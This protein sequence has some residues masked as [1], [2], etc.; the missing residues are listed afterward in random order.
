MSRAAVLRTH[1]SISIRILHAGFIFS[2][3]Q[4]SHVLAAPNTGEKKSGLPID[5]GLRSPVHWPAA[6]A[7]VHIA[8][9]STAHSR[10]L[11]WTAWCRSQRRSEATH[12]EA[13]AARQWSTPPRAR[14]TRACHLRPPC[15]AADAACEFQPPPPRLPLGSAR[16]WEARRGGTAALRCCSWPATIESSKQPR[17]PC[18]TRCAAA[19][20]A[21]PRKGNL[22]WSGVVG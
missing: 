21:R 22:D 7:S 16:A 12:L 5:C 2:H 13:S 6:A 19:E 18:P 3:L 1:S 8:T 9:F 11:H 20:P 15:S 4:K 14:S 10:S 17:A